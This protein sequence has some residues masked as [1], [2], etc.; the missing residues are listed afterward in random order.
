VVLEGVELEPMYD[1]LERIENVVEVQ[2]ARPFGVRAIA[3]A[4]VKTDGID[5]RMLGHVLRV[6][7]RSFPRQRSQRLGARSMFYT[8]AQLESAIASP[9]RTKTGATPP[10]LAFRFAGV[11]ARL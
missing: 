8:I 2:L 6:G 3:A 11:L 7:L 5:A 9:W 4:Q 10:C 1:W